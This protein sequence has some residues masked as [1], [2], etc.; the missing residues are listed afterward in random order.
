MTAE[1]SL[2][3]SAERPSIVPGR[4]HHTPPKRAATMKRRRY[5]HASPAEF[6]KAWQKSFSAREVARKVGST[7]GACFRRAYR[8]RENGVPLKYMMDVPAEPIDWDEL[9]EFARQLAPPED[10]AEDAGGDEVVTETPT[11]AEGGAGSD[12]APDLIGQGA[13]SG[14][15]ADGGDAQ[16]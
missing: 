12:P 3:M 11:P 5:S 16:V 4:I 1:M 14:S 10:D 2:E 6:I 13:S 8:Y 9:A 15:D 7:K